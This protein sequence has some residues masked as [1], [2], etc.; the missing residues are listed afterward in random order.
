M[1]FQSKHTAVCDLLQPGCQVQ[2][3]EVR[4]RINYVWY[5][6][7]VKHPSGAIRK[8]CHIHLRTCNSHGWRSIGIARIVWK[9]ESRLKGTADTAANIST[10]IHGPMN[11]PYTF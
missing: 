9:N 6:R 2:D 11:T 1:L 7:K 10:L 5:I 3:T 8:N 4:I